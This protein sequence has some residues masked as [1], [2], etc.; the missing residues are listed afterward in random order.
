[1]LFLGT[2]VRAQGS[3]AFTSTFIFNFNVD[4]AYVQFG[5]SNPTIQK[6]ANGDTLTVKNG[7]YHIYLSYPTNKDVYITK[8]ALRDSTYI[9]SHNFDLSKNEI[10]IESNNVSVKY[11]LGG[12]VVILSDWDSEIYV[13]GEYLGDEFAIFSIAES[14]VD[15]KNSVDF[16]VKNKRFYE[17]TSKIYKKDEV[18]IEYASFYQ[19]KGGFNAYEVL[20]GFSY[21]REKK[22]G[23][24]ALVLS[25]L[26]V[27]TGLF[28]HYENEYS[29]QLPE[30]N[31][32]RSLYLEEINE[33]SAAILGIRMQ[34]KANK[35]ESVNLKRNLAL[36]G[37]LAIM[38]IDVIDKFRI[39]KRSSRPGGTELDVFI[40]PKFQ[41]YLTI[42]A[43]LKF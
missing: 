4:T 24:M 17:R 20:P 43:E 36:G 6:V 25:G 33:T 29:S 35:M 14:S 27:S 15:F 1:M 16:T 11:L 41:K 39:N 37:I 28:L 12:D 32:I 42:G 30:Y 21:I 26:A 34:E 8:N 18:Q 9:F 23:K 31:S 19:K 40:A 2:Q 7:F 10:D 38:A 5:Q 13:E 22:Y 3:G